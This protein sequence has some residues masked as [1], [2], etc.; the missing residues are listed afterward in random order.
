M[1]SYPLM[2]HGRYEGQDVHLVASGPSM[3]G[4][5]YN[6]FNDKIVIAVNHACKLVKN[7]FVVYN[8]SNF[9]LRESPE[10]L[11]TSQRIVCA[12]NAKTHYER[13]YWFMPINKFTL[14]PAE[15]VYCARSSGLSALTVALQGQAKRIFLWG[16]DYRF[17]TLADAV[18]AATLNGASIDTVDKIVK[19]NRI[20]YGHSTSGQFF[21]RQDDPNHEMIF[22]D[23][24]NLFSVY[25]RENIFNMSEFSALPF[26]EK[27]SLSD[28][29]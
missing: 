4:F 7:D 19:S 12:R 27:K 20:Y 8:D 5:D 10:I 3:V 24:V 9:I 6:F 28:I 18:K 25:P 29:I 21:H 1:L 17:L 26:F 16:F 13:A 22:N 11:E 23:V 2:I 14:D 15:G